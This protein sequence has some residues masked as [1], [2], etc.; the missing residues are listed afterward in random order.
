MSLPLELR[1]AG[2]EPLLASEASAVEAEA[3]RFRWRFYSSGWYDP[4]GG[5]A[6]AAFPKSILTDELAHCRRTY[7]VVGVILK[8]GLGPGRNHLIGLGYD[9]GFLAGQVAGVRWHRAR[10][11]RRRVRTHFRCFAGQCA[12]HD[13]VAV[14]LEEFFAYHDG[15]LDP[16]RGG[17]GRQRHAEPSEP[18][19]SS[20]TARSCGAAWTTAASLWAIAGVVVWLRGRDVRRRAAATVLTLGVEVLNLTWWGAP[21]GAFVFSAVSAR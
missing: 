13:R 19:R 7:Y 4:K 1:D 11:S 21:Y 15:L 16:M 5:R 17:A 2:G 18:A 10:V 20:S 6:V 9:L 8:E 12:L 14:G 3:K